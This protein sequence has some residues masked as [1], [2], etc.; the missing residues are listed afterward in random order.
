MS[1]QTKT[2]VKTRRTFRE[3]IRADK[4]QRALVMI[5]FMADPA[6]TVYLRSLC[7]DDPLQLL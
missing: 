6:G 7:G 2:A 4:T 1:S 5:T 3:F